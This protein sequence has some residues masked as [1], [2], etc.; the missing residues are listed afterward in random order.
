MSGGNRNGMELAG[1]VLKRISPEFLVSKQKLRQAEGSCSVRLKR[2]EGK[3]NVG[4]S[5]RPFVLC[6]LP[7]RKPPRNKS[8]GIIGRW[9]A[10]MRDANGRERVRRRDGAGEP[11][12][13]H[14]PPSHTNAFPRTPTFQLVIQDSREYWSVVAVNLSQVNFGP[15]CPPNRQIGD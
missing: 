14:E 15:R 3:Q 7:V 1:S 10:R 11:R 13:K 8:R 12:L 2:E 5:S 4:L 9:S 6:G